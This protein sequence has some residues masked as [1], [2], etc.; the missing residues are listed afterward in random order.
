L[1]KPNGLLGDAY[2][3]AIKPFRYLLVYPAIM[4]EMGLKW[5]AVSTSAG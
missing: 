2:M 3:A 5:R 4:R 1:T